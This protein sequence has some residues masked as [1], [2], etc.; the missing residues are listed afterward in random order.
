MPRIGFY[1]LNKIN[2]NQKNRKIQARGTLSIN[3]SCSKNNTNLEMVQMGSWMNE[4]E[5]FRCLFPKS[6]KKFKKIEKNNLATWGQFIKHDASINLNLRNK[7]IKN[8]RFPIKSYYYHCSVNDLKSHIKSVMISKKIFKSL[9][10]L[11]MV[12]KIISN[13]N[14]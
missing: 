2:N 1:K 9:Q 13:K 11:F 3:K 8:Y 7:F 6:W 14:F 12:D 4:N 5:N 10:F